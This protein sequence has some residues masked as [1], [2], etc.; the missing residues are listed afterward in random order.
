M[1]SIL[2]TVYGNPQVWELYR[3]CPETSMKLYVHE[4]GF[5]I[6]VWLCV[7]TI[8]ARKHVF[9]IPN[10]IIVQS[11]LSIYTS[12]YSFTCVPPLFKIFTLESAPSIKTCFIHTSSDSCS[13]FKYLNWW[14]PSSWSRP[15]NFFTSSGLGPCLCPPSRSN[16][17]VV[18]GIIENTKNHLSLW[19]Q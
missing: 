18:G 2:R 8:L 9:R 4:L 7:Q 6:C 11:I 10:R 19:K 5:W 14:R 12:L 13:P 15:L 1:R 17:G 16:A 3:L